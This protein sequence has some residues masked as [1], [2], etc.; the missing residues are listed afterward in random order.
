MI[1]NYRYFEALSNTA[2]EDSIANSERERELRQ[3]LRNSLIE[4]GQAKLIERSKWI[5][6]GVVPNLIELTLIVIARQ[7]EE[8]NL[9]R[10]EGRI[11]RAEYREYKQ[12]FIKGTNLREWWSTR[13][14]TASSSNQ[15]SNDASS[16]GALIAR[17]L[18]IAERTDFTLRRGDWLPVNQDESSTTGNEMGADETAM[19]L[20]QIGKTLNYLCDPL[21]PPSP[22]LLLDNQPQI[23]IA[24]V[25]S[26]DL[27]DCST[28]CEELARRT[29]SVVVS[30]KGTINLAAEAVA[31]AAIA[32]EAE[33]VGTEEEVENK[34][35]STLTVAL[36][37]LGSIEE[38]DENRPILLATALVEQVKEISLRSNCGGWVLKGWPCKFHF[39][40]IFFLSYFFYLIFFIFRFSLQN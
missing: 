14:S 37:A 5:G 32:A 12:L 16:Y 26:P 29:R 33:V 10:E 20:E 18:D 21:L 25:G 9:G 6:G 13:S 38:G 23:G 22:P 36:E 2:K 35:K 8:R 17:Q 19:Q 15:A 27:I 28:F 7:S 34:E 24:V 40:R 3:T 31:S 4:R 30:V 39:Y 1:R 11:G